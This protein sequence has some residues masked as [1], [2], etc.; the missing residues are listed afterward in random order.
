[1]ETVR[2]NSLR[3]GDHYRATKVLAEYHGRD[4]YRDLDFFDLRSVLDG[5]NRL[6]VLDV[7]GLLKTFKTTK[8]REVEPLR[9]HSHELYQGSP[10][11]RPTD[12]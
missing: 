2:K 10:D 9:Y 11:N 1:M 12:Q 8:A 3:E 6:G 4:G 7:S 5:K